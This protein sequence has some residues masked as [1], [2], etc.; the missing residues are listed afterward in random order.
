MPKYALKGYKKTE[1]AHIQFWWILEREQT[2][3]K[4]VEEKKIRLI[5][6]YNVF[7]KIKPR[8]HYN[9]LGTPEFAPSFPNFFIFININTTSNVLCF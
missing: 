3:Q 1:V 2:S 8:L 6:S 7:V 4:F 5:L 9:I